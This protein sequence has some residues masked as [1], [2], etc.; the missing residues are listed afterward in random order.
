M[1]DQSTMTCASG[2]RIG[3]TAQRACAALALIAWALGSAHAARADTLL[4]SPTELFSGSTAAGYQVNVPGPG[5]LFVNFSNIDYAP[6]VASDLSLL[7]VSGA[8]VL[9]SLVNE[10]GSAS[11][12]TISVSG[13][14]TLF[15]YVVGAATGSLNLGLYSLD[16]VFRP[17]GPS[18]PNGPPS[19]V[20][21]PSSIWLMLGG[22]AAIGW[23]LRYGM[24]RLRTP[25]AFSSV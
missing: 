2:S 19:P 22:L 21:L 10:T 12:P 20:P 16:V 8:D 18:D 3:R 15:A 1:T 7:L 13:A 24:P 5:S 25:A 6:G 4:I 11:L 23:T 17:N 9:G 14:S